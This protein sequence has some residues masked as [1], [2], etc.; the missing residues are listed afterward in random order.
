M[1]SVQELEIR[2]RDLMKG[3]DAH[4]LPQRSICKEIIT[5]SSI[6]AQLRTICRSMKDLIA[7]AYELQRWKATELLAFVITDTD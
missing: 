2:S 1:L 6:A 5:K 3:N 7:E 4:T